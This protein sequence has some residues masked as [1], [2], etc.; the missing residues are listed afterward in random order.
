MPQLRPR[1]LVVSR[2]LRALRRAAQRRRPR[3]ERAGN[4]N[5]NRTGNGIGNEPGNG[6]GAAG[7]PDS[8]LRKRGGDGFENMEASLG[9]NLRGHTV[10]R[11]SGGLHAARRLAP[12][13]QLSGYLA[14]GFGSAQPR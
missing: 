9:G 2:S 11:G 7:L 10:Q 13:R 12:G 8:Y 5:G 14:E 1:Q 4:G 6:T 3:S